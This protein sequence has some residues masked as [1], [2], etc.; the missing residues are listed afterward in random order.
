LAHQFDGRRAKQ[1]EM[2][3]AL[4]RG[5]P[6]VNDAAKCFKQ[7]GSPM[8]LVDD[9]EFSGLRSQERVRIVR[10]PLVDGPFEIQ[11]DSR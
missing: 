1:Q 8:D 10:T 6:F 5:S 2:P 11:V 7:C 9:H 3:G 4:A